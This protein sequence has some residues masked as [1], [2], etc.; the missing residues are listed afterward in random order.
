MNL[1][2]KSRRGRVS[3][4]PWLETRPSWPLALVLEQEGLSSGGFELERDEVTSN[5]R[6]QQRRLIRWSVCNTEME[7]RNPEGVKCSG[8]LS[9]DGVSGSGSG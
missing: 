5:V 3:W 1:Y 2:L 7:I 8:W 9:G 4:E 6:K